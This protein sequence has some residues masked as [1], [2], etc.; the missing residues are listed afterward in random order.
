[1]LQVQHIAKRV[2][3]GKE[4]LKDIHFS[5]APGEFIVILGP[6][7]AGKSM[8]L[9]C[10]N[11]LIQP[12]RGEV[13]LRLPGAA[14]IAIHAASGR[15]L[16]QARQHISMVFQGLHLVGRLT[17]LENVM[18]GGL[19]QMSSF[20][21][22]LMGFSDQEAEKA[23]QLLA[24]LHIGDLAFRRVATLSGGEA[25]RVALARALFQEPALLLA[26]EPVANLDPSHAHA[27]MRIFRDQIHRMPVVAVLHQ[28]DL[29]AEY[30][31]RVIGI[32]DGKVV[33]DGPPRLSEA[34]LSAL[35][36][37]ELQ[38]IKKSSTLSAEI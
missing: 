3:G 12:T 29:A 4:I 17:A 30:G 5:V 8:T 33:Y 21:S 35:Y 6:S 22:I 2:Q 11:G 7:G 20:R 26:D 25:Q 15:S 37:A 13:I 27:I 31:T 10:L 1:M 19:G 24:E 32:R 34:D 9:R 16:R 14:P 36:G 18:V 23:Y 28:P 38:E